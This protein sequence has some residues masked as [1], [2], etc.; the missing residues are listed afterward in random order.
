MESMAWKTR[1]FCESAGLDYDAG[2]L[3]EH[4]VIGKNVRVDI[5]TEKQPGYK[6]R[7]KVVD[8]LPRDGAPPQQEEFVATDADVP[9]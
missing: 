8:Y 5:T 9:F 7:N 4:E 3:D 6:P 1:H 2:E